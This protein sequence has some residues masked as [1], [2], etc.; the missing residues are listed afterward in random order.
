MVIIWATTGLEPE[1]TEKINLLVPSFYHWSPPRWLCPRK[2]FILKKKE[3][4]F[5]SY[6]IIWMQLCIAT[7]VQFYIIN[8]SLFSVGWKRYE[9][10]NIKN[11]IMYCLC[12]G[13]VLRL[14]SKQEQVI[15]YVDRRIIPPLIHTHTLVFKFYRLIPI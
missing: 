13:Y 2:N 14:S 4:K 5:I 7:F 6:K 15:S 1:T 12:V 8:V 3:K 9:L 10:S 11:Q